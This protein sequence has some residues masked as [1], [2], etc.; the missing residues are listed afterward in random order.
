MRTAPYARANPLESQPYDKN[1][2]I[3][4]DEE[5]IDGFVD[6]LLAWALHR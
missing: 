5:T 3:R 1:L 6:A 4:F 2:G